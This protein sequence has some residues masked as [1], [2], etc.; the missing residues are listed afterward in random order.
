MPPLEF[1]ADRSD[2]GKTVAEMLRKRFHLTWARAKRLVEGGHVRIAGMYCAD[3]AQR[4]RHK[5]RVWIRD[6]VLEMKSVSLPSKAPAAAAKGKPAAPKAAKPKPARELVPVAVA[7]AGL[8]LVYADAAVVV[9]D[10]PAGLTTMRHADEAEEFGPRGRAY[11]P[12]TLADYLPLLV[13]EPRA[14]FFA[15]HRLDRDTTGLVAFART[16]AAARHLSKQ[17]KAHTVERRYLALVRGTAAAGRIDSTLVRD[18]GDGRRGSGPADAPDGKRAVTHVLVVE[19]YAATA[20]VECRLETGRT[21]QVRIHLGEAGTPLCGE[22]VYDRPPHG[23]PVPDPS[24]VERPMLHAARLGF[25]HPDGVERLEW[26]APLPEDFAALMG[27]MRHPA[28]AAASHTRVD[29][30]GG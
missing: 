26:D 5:N 17:F 22:R 4:I 20:L 29:R 24:K 15:V 16:P 27:R 8:V 30:P 13:G 28:D 1:L 25:T 14:R 19:Q 2:A 18:R 21:H 7:P 12:K 9:V 3:P 11:L 23:Q 10:K 6:G